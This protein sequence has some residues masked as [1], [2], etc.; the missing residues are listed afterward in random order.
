MKLAYFTSTPNFG[1]QLNPYVFNHFLPGLFDEDSRITFLGI[2]SVLGVI[3]PTPSV[4]KF[5]VFSTGYAYGNPPSDMGLYEFWC[6][7]GPET[8]AVLGLDASLAIADGAILLHCMPHE[9]VQTVYPYAFMPHEHT[10]MSYPAWRTMAEEVGLHYISP[11]APV[12]E[13]L[14]E[15]RQTGVL[16]TE[17]LHGAIV[18]DT[19]GIPWVP[20]QLMASINR[21]KWLDWTRSMELPLDVQVFAPLA[22]R[23]SSA[24]IIR[25]HLNHRAEP[26]AGLAPTL[27]WFYHPSVMR[28]RIREAKRRLLELRGR[29]PFLSNR[30]LVEAKASRLLDKL[31]ALKAA[32]VV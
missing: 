22:T 4:E 25:H 26:L 18:A 21:F 1:D 13:V 28:R 2:G 30:A 17:A 31:M 5:V 23:Q 19:F 3:Q 10:H 24:A 32:Y 29:E 15:I 16:L 9:P 12:D 27:A 6:V 11:H 8:A 20:L 7:R 14:R